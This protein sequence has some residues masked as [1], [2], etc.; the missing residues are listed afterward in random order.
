MARQV[1][2]KES[3]PSRAKQDSIDFGSFL[4]RCSINCSIEDPCPSVPRTA[5]VNTIN[6]Q[7]AHLSGREKAASQNEQRSVW[8]LVC[9]SCRLTTSDDDLIY[10]NEDE[11][12]EEANESH[13]N[14]AERCPCSDLVK[15]FPVRLGAP[16]D[17]AGAVLGEF[18]QRCNDRVHIVRSSTRLS[19]P[20][21]EVM[22]GSNLKS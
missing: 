4:V 22:P 3:T 2:A 15:F 6:S 17:Q 18:L 12:N 11:F 14:E 13:R 1:G 10:R 7:C 8:L 9:N 20:R 5:S 16:F 21:L 19:L